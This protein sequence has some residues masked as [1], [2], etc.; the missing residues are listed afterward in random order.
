MTRTH[1]VIVAAAHSLCGV[2]DYPG[3]DPGRILAKP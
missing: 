2:L 3:G 1:A